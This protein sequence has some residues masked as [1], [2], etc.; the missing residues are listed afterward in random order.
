MI[1]GSRAQSDPG[2]GG[3]RP[4]PAA[5]ILG[6]EVFR[7]E[8]EYWTIVYHGTVLRLRDTKGLRYLAYLLARPGQPVPASDLLGAVPRAGA[9]T[10]NARDGYGNAA[11]E[12]ARLAVTK[13]IRSAIKRI[14]AHSAELG[15]HLDT[16]VRTGAACTYLADPERLL[17]W[18]T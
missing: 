18:E 5:D 7:R 14:G 4:H 17:A 8:G 9:V 3:Q 12:R 6:A 11:A 10:A 13:R 1:P 15:H 16:N 2:A